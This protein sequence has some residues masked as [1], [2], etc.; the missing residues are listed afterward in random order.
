MQSILK[1]CLKV[2]FAVGIIVWLTTSGKLDFSLIGQS[3]SSGH[4]WAWCF[5]LLV[6]Q[7]FGSSIR[8]LWLLRQSP[9]LSALTVLQSAR[10]TWIGLF[11]NS[12]LPGAV[13]GD[14]IKLLYAKDIAPKLSKTFLVTSVLVD[15]ILGLIGLILI[16]GISSTLFYKEILSL[17]PQMES[18]INFNFLLFAGAIGFIIFLLMPRKTQEL[19]LKLVQKIPVIGNKAY[20]TLQSFWL[21]GDN[22]LVL[23]KCI[24]LSGLL[25]SIAFYGF[26][27]ITS[28]FY[29]HPLPFPYIV[30]FIPLGIM[31]VAIPI[32]PAGLGV[33]HMAFDKLFSLVGIEGGASFFN[34]Y[35]LILISVNALGVIPYLL[36]SKRHKITKA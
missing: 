32:S 3:F 2:L 5:L 22:K 34:L 24:L 33:G 20:K 10:L 11:F 31:A 17:S 21:L 16:L 6:I 29:S 1:T 12:F 28:P 35:F 7:S 15:R 19:I 8:W 27:V 14:L 36:S 25:Q 26:Y 18:L 30:T 13:T 4:T 23:M 9:D